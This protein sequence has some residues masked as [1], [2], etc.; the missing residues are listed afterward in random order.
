MKLYTDAAVNGNPG[1]AG[2]GFII[3]E[4]DKYEQIS[5]PLLG[6]W[7]NH[8]AE[9]EAVFQSLEWIIQQSLSNT[10]L[11]L[12]TDSKLVA[13]SISKKYAKRAIFSEYVRK[14]LHLLNH[15]SFYEIQWI[16]ESKNKGADNLARQ[17]LQKAIKKEYQ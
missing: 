2:I 10:F 15:F 14:I 12:Y 5:I 4:D 17:G 8:T 6:K 9:F 7:D 3:L 16:P 1:Q 13:D 11:F